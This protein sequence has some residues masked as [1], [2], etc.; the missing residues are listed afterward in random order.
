VKVTHIELYQCLTPTRRQESIRPIFWANRTKSYISRT[1]N[2]DE[3]PNGRFGDARSPAYG[4]LD[5]YGVS[6]KQTVRPLPYVLSLHCLTSQQKEDAYKLWGHPTTLSDITSLFSRF[7]S[8]DLLALPWSDQKPATE[9]TTIS[10]QLAR[11]N[12][13]GFL[14]INSQPAVNGVRSDDKVFGWGPSNGYVYQKV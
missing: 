3:Y 6:I 7:C 9:T 8:G 10:S 13:Y 2:W 14:T 5:G 11:M 1:E 12:E 4:E